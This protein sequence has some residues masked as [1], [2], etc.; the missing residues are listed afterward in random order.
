MFY[1]LNIN[2]IE[3]IFR[4]SGYLENTH[5]FFSYYSEFLKLSSKINLYKIYG[6]FSST[7]SIINGHCSV[8]QGLANRSEKQYIIWHDQQLGIF[9]TI[10]DCMLVLQVLEIVISMLYK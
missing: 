2:L 9:L 7:K 5:F 8:H 3:Y 6:T 1:I 4:N 10:K